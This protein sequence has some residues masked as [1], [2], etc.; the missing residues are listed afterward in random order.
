M[1]ARRV[2][3]KVAEATVEGHQDAILHPDGL[4]YDGVDRPGESLAHHRGDVV[5]RLLQQRRAAR[6]SMFSSSLNL[7][8]RGA[9]QAPRGRG[10]PRR[11]RRRGI[12]STLS[13]G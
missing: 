6:T 2:G 11:R 1:G 3:A 10:R 12:P 4:G 7:T 5:A 9:A 13:V 8:A